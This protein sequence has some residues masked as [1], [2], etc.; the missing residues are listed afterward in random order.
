MSGGKSELGSGL[1]IR[2]Q[3][4][5]MS[6]MTFPSPKDLPNPE[7]EPGSPVG[8]ADSLPSEPPGCMSQ[9]TLQFTGVTTR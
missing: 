5:G 8:Q 7:I 9:N 4:K 3:E 2:S 6:E 1:F